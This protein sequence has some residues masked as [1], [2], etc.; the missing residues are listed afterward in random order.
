MKD[1]DAT[2]VISAERLYVYHFDWHVQDCNRSEAEVQF[3]VR[4]HSSNYQSEDSVASFNIEKRNAS[5]SE[6][7]PIWVLCSNEALKV[8]TWCPAKDLISSCLNQSWCF[9]AT[10]GQSVSGQEAVSCLG[11]CCYRSQQ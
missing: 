3:V 6:L 8:I 2:T 9:C 4:Q 10:E 5:P 11:T 1:I 7:L